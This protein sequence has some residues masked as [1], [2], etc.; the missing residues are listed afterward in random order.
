LKE[1]FGPSAVTQ[2]LK[3]HLEENDWWLRAVHAPKICG[4]L[5]LEC[6]EPSYYRDICVWLPD[7]RWG[8]EALPPCPTFLISNRVGVHCWRGNHAGCR[9]VA[10][11]THYFAISRRYICH[12]CEDAAAAVKTAAKA[13][14][15]AVPGLRVVADEDEAA[16]E[17]GEVRWRRGVKINLPFLHF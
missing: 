11:D 9:V 17:D 4:F 3:K 12:G 15:Q 14:A 13:A 8:I 16:V 2:E 6:T 1:E 10:L 7:E 5:G